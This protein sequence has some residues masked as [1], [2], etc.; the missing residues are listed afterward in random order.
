MAQRTVDPTTIK[1]L[2]D[3]VARWPKASNLGFDPETREA[4]IYDTTKE[5]VKVSSIPWKRAADTITVLSQPTRFSASTLEGA[6]GRYSKFQEQR[7]QMRDVAEQQLRVTEA[8]LL[9]AWR[10][11][12]AA[13]PAARGA[14]RHDIIAAEMAIRDTESNMADKNRMRVW[15]PQG[16]MAA[17]VPPMP[18][19]RRGLTLEEAK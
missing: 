1:S 14:L 8:A 18:S 19:K 7:G 6:M 9:D 4:T 11:Y 16:M 5:R 13:P 3:W 10:V 15:L 2:A 12:E 17:H